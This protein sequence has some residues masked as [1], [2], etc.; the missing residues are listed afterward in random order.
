MPGTG[1]D[2]LH[3][4]YDLIIPTVICSRYY[5]REIGVERLNN[6]PKITE[7]IKGRARV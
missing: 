1:P 6:L 5:Y 4:Y 2:V 7:V 3:M